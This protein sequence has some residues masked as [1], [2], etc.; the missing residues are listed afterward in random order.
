MVALSYSQPLHFGD[1]GALPLKILWAILDLFT[2]YVL[3]TGLKLWL[4]KRRTRADAQGRE[5][6]GGGAP[7]PAA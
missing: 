6:E 3:W 2:L 4:G 5:V 7:M 1:Y